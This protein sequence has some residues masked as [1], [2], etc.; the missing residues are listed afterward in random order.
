MQI[1]YLGKLLQEGLCLGYP[2]SAGLATD[3]LVEFQ[4]RPQTKVIL[5]P[6]M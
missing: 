5:V 4:M 1:V 6:F 3:P 2:L